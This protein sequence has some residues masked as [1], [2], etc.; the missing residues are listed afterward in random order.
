MDK[1]PFVLVNGTENEAVWNHMVRT[2]HYLGYDKM[3]RRNYR[4]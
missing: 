3:I 4:G 1:P 2:W